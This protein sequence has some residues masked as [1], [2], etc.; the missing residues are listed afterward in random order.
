[1]SKTQAKK[2]EVAVMKPN[3]VAKVDANLPA[4]LQG[5]QGPTGAEGIETTDLVIPRIK[6]GQSM[7]AE[8]K[9]GIVEE[10]EL[11][12]NLTKEVLAQAD[13]SLPLVPLW[14]GKE[15]ILWRPQEDN[16]GGILARAKPVVENGITRY[17]WDKP[18]QSFEVK[19]GGKIK[20]TWKT[21]N[22]ID[23]DGLDQWGSEIPG[24]N[25]SGI[26]A[27]AHHNYIVALPTKD[28]MVAA[29][30]LAKSQVKKAKNFNSL[31]KL[32]SA[33]MW[34][35][36]FN[37]HIVDEQRSA[38]EKY[39]NLDL[40]PAGFVSEDAFQRYADMA[41]SFQKAA[42]VIDQTDEDQEKADDRD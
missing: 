5:Y 31:L 1:M 22:Y 14:R 32:G 15:F 11:F 37:T 7:T 3:A 28:D 9:E 2:Q 38:T 12:L 20:V 4:Y 10:G 16:G 29:L 42:F 6:L 25:E 8:V 34:A 23:E 40:K 33:P 24:D 39:K 27:T 30:S 18:N 36:V 17:K 35:R 21:K 41:K 26:A 19:V 13:A